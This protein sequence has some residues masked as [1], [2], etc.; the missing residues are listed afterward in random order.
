MGTFRKMT[1][2]DGVI[3]CFVYFG[4]W[5]KKISTGTVVWVANRDT[6]ITDKSGTL[7]VKKDG[8][9][10]ILSGAVNVI[11]SSNSNV[12]LSS[13]DPVS[14][15]KHDTTKPTHFLDYILQPKIYKCNQLR[16][17]MR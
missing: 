15:N 7:K 17:D 2:T 6:P 1:A 4:I 8:N 3:R 14:T 5:F 11:W 16:I 13:S 9:L 10:V 12:S